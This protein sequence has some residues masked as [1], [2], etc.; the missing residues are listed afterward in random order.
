[1]QVA[2]AAARLLS[3]LH[4][5]APGRRMAAM[6]QAYLQAGLQNNYDRIESLPL[7]LSRIG[8]KLTAAGKRG[9]FP[10]SLKQ[11]FKQPDNLQ[12]FSVSDS[13][14]PK[15]SVT[16]R[17][18]DLVADHLGKMRPSAGP[19]R[20]LPFRIVSI[21]T[22]KGSQAGSSTGSDLAASKDKVCAGQHGSI[23]RLR[24]ASCC[25]SY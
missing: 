4:P 20:G 8:E 5:L 3:M 18:G 23:I 2:A 19:S 25:L 12:Y 9:E 22:H 21:P 7:K 13:G 11:F 24:Y 17:I 16:M 1:M 15:I 10:S 14:S 6:G